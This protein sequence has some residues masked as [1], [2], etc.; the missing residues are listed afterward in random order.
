MCILPN[1]PCVG[2]SH[3]S[4]VLA[5]TCRSYGTNRTRQD[6]EKFLDVTE[7]IKNSSIDVHYTASPQAYV[8]SIAFRTL[9]FF[10]T[11]HLQNLSE[12]G[13]EHPDPLPT[14][15]PSLQPQRW[16][17]TSNLFLH[18]NGSVKKV[19]STA[20]HPQDTLCRNGVNHVHLK[21]TLLHSSSASLPTL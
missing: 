13:N 12:N 9:F 14:W 1:R 7:F 5:R 4:S 16:H 21:H 19:P 8:L 20:D 18:F 10:L 2:Q 6:F 11:F 15:Q 17:R 3:F